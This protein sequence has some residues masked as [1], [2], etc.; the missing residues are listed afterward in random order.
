M[1]LV[2]FL[3]ALLTILAGTAAVHA[4]NPKSEIG[5]LISYIE[6][7]E[8][9]FIRGG[10]EY[11]AKEGADHMRKKLARAG[12]RVKTAEEFIQGVASKS[13]LT[14]GAYRVKL[15]DGRTVPTG[16]WLTEALTKQ[17]SSTRRG[18]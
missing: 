6:R 17:R 16:P 8:V 13:Y 12:S 14:G 11:S 10:K 4:D 1:P 18:Q 5:F 15:A 7:S 9:R 2:S 3:L